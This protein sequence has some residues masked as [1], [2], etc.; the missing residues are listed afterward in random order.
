M[1]I[2]DGGI[3]KL[4]LV[5]TIAA[6]VRR[7]VREQNLA[8]DEN[9][10]VIVWFRPA[11][12]INLAGHRALHFGFSEKICFTSIFNS[13]AHANLQGE[14]LYVLTQHCQE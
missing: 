4:R 2:E 8:E 3:E 5:Y 10:D 14:R 9:M 11:V 7:I 1:Q 6:K 13:R 12:L